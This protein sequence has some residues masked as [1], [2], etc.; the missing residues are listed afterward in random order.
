[1]Q[2]VMCRLLTNLLPT[3]SLNGLQYKYIIWNLRINC[4]ILSILCKLYHWYRYQSSCYIMQYTVNLN[5][6][7]NVIIDRIAFLSLAYYVLSNPDD[8]SIYK[9]ILIR[10]KFSA[11]NIFSTITV[12]T[13]MF[14]SKWLMETAVVFLSRS[15]WCN[16]LDKTWYVFRP[17]SLAR[18]IALLKQTGIDIDHLM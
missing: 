6:K 18:W 14:I 8:K 4:S 12:F 9:N 1:M 16:K 10:V 15:A 3:V 5:I 13:D 17:K 7:T 2:S 11:W